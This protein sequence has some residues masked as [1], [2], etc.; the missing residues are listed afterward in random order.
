M[1]NYDICVSLLNDFTEAQL[2]HVAVILRA[3]KQIISDIEVAK[4]Q[5]ADEEASHKMA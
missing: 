5:K 3:M 2:A 1:N 4:Q